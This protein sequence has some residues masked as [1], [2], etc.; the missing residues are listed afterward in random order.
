M[1]KFVFALFVTIVFLASIHCLLEAQESKMT[2]DEIKAKVEGIDKNVNSILNDISGMKKLK[3]SG[4]LHFQFEKTESGKGLDLGNN[5]YTLNPYDSTDSKIQSRFRLRRNFVKIEYNAGL[6]QIV[7]QVD[8]TNERLDLKEAYINITDPWLKYFTLRTGIFYRPNY[9][10]ESSPSILESIDR[11]NIVRK[12]YPGERDLGAM[13]IIKPEKLF[14]LQVAAFNNTYKGY[15]AQYWPNFNSEPFYYMA[16]LTKDFMLKDLGLG[17]NIGVHARIGNILAN[18]NK[19]IESENN[20]TKIDTTSIKKGDK[21]GRKWYGIEAQVYYDFLAGTKLA[22]EYIFGSG[23]DEESLDN[24]ASA[25]S[26]IRKRDFSGFYILL[27]QGITKEWQIVGKY[28]LYNPNTKIAGDDVNNK[29]DLSF[30][31][32]GLGIHNFS[33]DNIRLTLWYDINNTTTNKNVLTNDP[34]DNF[35]YLRFQFKY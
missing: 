30:S 17:F 35:L 18:T 27:A 34:I 23:I 24:S 33:F 19:I 6:A 22:G 4:F 2:F 7:A 13:L 31:T 3:I 26:A 12:L 16:R 14:S 9:E 32:L 11:S 8:F 10:V 25:P 21:I 5:N 1:K 28:E 15:S 20:S 29:S